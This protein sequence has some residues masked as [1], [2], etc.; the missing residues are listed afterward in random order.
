MSG[1]E[2]REEVKSIRGFLDLW[3][4]G[5]D[6]EV[7]DHRDGENVVC[8]TG[9]SQM[10]QALMWSG[11]Q[12]Q[13]ASLGVTSPTYM[14]PLYG[15]VGSGTTAATK[16]DTQLTAELGRVTVGAGGSTPAS[17][18]VAAL[19]TWLFYFPNPAVM[20]SV[21]EAGIFCQ[22]SSAA[23]SGAMLNHWVFPAAIPV[24]TADTLVLQVAL[25]LGP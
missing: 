13:A 2:A 22:A 10:A 1:A 4:V 25:A 24:P 8:T 7:K 18:T 21:N 23:N 20:W 17:P 15:A 19:V 12:D 14:T 11:I 9:F 16:A 5:P 6:G 3:V